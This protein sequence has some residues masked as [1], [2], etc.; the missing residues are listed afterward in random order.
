MR[1]AGRRRGLRRRPGDRA[2][3]AAPGSSSAAGTRT[4]WPTAS[5]ALLADP[6]RAARMGAAGRDRIVRDWSGPAQAE[7]LLGFLRGTAPARR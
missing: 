6:D 7:R 4:R 5:R 1:A 3:R 2:T